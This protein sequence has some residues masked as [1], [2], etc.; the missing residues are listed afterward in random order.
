[1]DVRQL[2]L[3]SGIGGVSVPMKV[4]RGR[5]RGS[6]EPVVPTHVFAGDITDT[7]ALERWIATLVPARPR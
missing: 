6:N 7:A 2:R 3:P 5:P 1:M 4:Y